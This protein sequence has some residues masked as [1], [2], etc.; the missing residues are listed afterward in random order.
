VSFVLPLFD[1]CVCSVV[2]LC[3]YCMVI[4]WLCW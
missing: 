2:L 4:M 3:C 1:Y